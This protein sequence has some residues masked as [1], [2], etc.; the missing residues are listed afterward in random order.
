MTKAKLSRNGK[1]RKRVTFLRQRNSPREEGCIN[2][3]KVLES[4]RQKIRE[5]EYEEEDFHDDDAEEETKHEHNE[6]NRVNDSNKPHFIPNPQA[7]YVAEGLF[8]T[9]YLSKRDSQCNCMIGF[10]TKQMKKL[11]TRM[12]GG[13]IG[14]FRKPA[15]DYGRC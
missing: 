2:D 3:E 5:N 6:K 11:C 14:V 7:K 12:N 15:K 10:K 8:D 4:E 1:L 13:V 9:Y